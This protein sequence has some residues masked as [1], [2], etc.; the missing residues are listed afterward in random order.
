MEFSRYVTTSSTSNEVLNDNN[1]VYAMHDDT[2]E[3]KKVLVI[4]YKRLKKHYVSKVQ[5]IWTGTKKKNS[6]NSNSIVKQQS[7]SIWEAKANND[8]WLVKTTNFTIR[9]GDFMI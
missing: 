8:D 3:R 9:N 5:S 4:K 7:L 2:M 6:K 1:D